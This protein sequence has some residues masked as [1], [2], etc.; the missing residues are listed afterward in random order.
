MIRSLMHP[1]FASMLAIVSFAGEALAVVPALFTYQG[2]LSDSSSQPVSA[3]LQMTFRIYNQAGVQRYEESQSVQVTNGL[4]TAVIGATVP[5]ALQ[6][7]ETYLLGI[8]IAGGAEMTPRQ[9][10]TANLY[11]LRAAAA[12]GLAASASVSGSQVSG[13]ITTAT[14]STSNLTGNIVGSQ[15]ASG[16]VT[17]GKLSASGTAAAGKVLGTDGSNLAWQ[18]ASSGTV[19]SVG[20]GTGLT[21]GPITG[22]GTIAIANG[23]VGAA[24]LANGAVDTSKLNTAS[25]DNRYF[26]NG[27]NTFGSY[28]IVGTNDNFPVYV[29]VNGD[30]LLRLIPSTDTANIVAGIGANAVGPNVIG[31]T[32][33]GGG[34]RTLGVNNVLGNWGTVAGGKANTAGK[35]DANQ[36]LYTHATVGGGSNN[37]ATGSWSTIS[38]GSGN[39]AS[40][41]ESTSSGGVNNVASGSDS[42]VAG[43]YG[44][45]ATGGSATIAGGFL[46]KATGTA[47]MIPGGDSNLAQGLYSFAAGANAKAYNRG[48]FM[49]HDSSTVS[50]VDCIT[51]NQFVAVATGGVW[52]TTGTDG[53]R[54]NIGGG[55]GNSWTCTSDANLKTELEP[56][57]GV[58]TLRKL[59]S[60]PV[61]RWRA[62]ADERRIPHAG[63]TA[64]DF[65]AAFGLGDDDKSIGFYDAQGVALSAIQGLYRLLEQKDAVIRDYEARLARLESAAARLAAVEVRLTALEK[66]P[67]PLLADAMRADTAAGPLSAENE[68]MRRQSDR[69]R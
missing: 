21:G 19:T 6:F 29:S 27:G 28:A 30:F 68:T 50:F 40:G 20:S 60:L 48:C 16:A 22:A 39:Q 18:T 3:T 1:V 64:Q 38:G 51:D 52:F 7:N 55:S 63:P 62:K 67:T 11:A 15:I 25:V 4:F 2:I 54:C 14:L 53:W 35:T 32:I 45:Q 43:G 59:A 46:N 66:E 33:G 69:R 49:W 65:M 23:G 9:A 58:E 17:Q 42:T 31:A 37:S 56:L 41:D 24:Q 57:D 12:E 10:I 5:L 34:S 13:A 44:N 61:Y 26:K 47:T 36:F 8:S